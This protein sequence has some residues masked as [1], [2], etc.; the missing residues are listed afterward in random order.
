MPSNHPLG[1]YR[2]R[3]ARQREPSSNPDVSTIVREAWGSQNSLDR[4]GISIQPCCC[5]VDTY[6]WPQHI[7]LAPVLLRRSSSTSRSLH[8]KIIQ[9]REHRI[10]SSICH[11]VSIATTSI[12]LLWTGNHSSW[13]LRCLRP[14]TAKTMRYNPAFSELSSVILTW[15]T[16]IS[17]WS[18]LIADHTHLLYNRLM[19]HI[20][21][22]ETT[23]LVLTHITPYIHNKLPHI[24]KIVEGKGLRPQA[25]WIIAYRDLCCRY[26]NTSNPYFQHQ[27]QTFHQSFPAQSILSEGSRLSAMAPPVMAPV[28]ELQSFVQPQQHSQPHYGFSGQWRAN[29]RGVFPSPQRSQNRGNSQQLALLPTSEPETRNPSVEGYA[30]VPVNPRFGDLYRPKQRDN[31]GNPTTWEHIVTKEEYTDDELRVIHDGIEVWA[32]LHTHPEIRRLGADHW[33]MVCD[34][35]WKAK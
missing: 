16:R 2:G 29:T 10:P 26:P 1:K 24:I 5:E 28:Q 30:Y 20:F 21:Q 4:W 3:H 8:S 27:I 15:S 25:I 14:I 19:G 32:Y 12:H 35:R 13:H 31:M 22:M 18:H 6:T 33:N 23:Y 11:R 9:E 7:A 34:A 17:C